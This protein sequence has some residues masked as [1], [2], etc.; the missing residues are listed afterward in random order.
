MS[1]N[2]Q[3][4]AVD[5]P[6]LPFTQPTQYGRLLQQLIVT[7]PGKGLP[8]PIM[9][10][11]FPDFPILNNIFMSDPSLQQHQ[12]QD[13]AYGGSDEDTEDYDP[14]QDY[15]EGEIFEG[16][17]QQTAAVQQLPAASKPLA[18]AS[19]LKPSGTG[20]PAEKEDQVKRLQ[21][22]RAQLLAQKG[23]PKLPN[24]LT[25]PTEPANMRKSTP[26]PAVA[27]SKGQP[28]GVILA[29][30]DLSTIDLERLVAQ[31]KAAAAAQDLKD[32]AAKTTSVRA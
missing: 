30:P 16:D 25:P 27:T 22:L 7:W 29:S 19:A 5:D 28:S 14:G 15:D 13:Q 11:P 31:G 3:Y 18:S 2:W 26:A 17:A 6:L 4:R 9:P 8:P 10:P 24:T 23:T 20:K 12:Q 21:D 1:A 32:K